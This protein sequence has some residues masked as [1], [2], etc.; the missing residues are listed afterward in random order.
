MEQICLEHPTEAAIERYL[1]NH[2][3]EAEFERVDTHLFVCGQCL[4]RVDEIR[5]FRVAL[6]DG[7]TLFRYESAERAEAKVGRA[8]VRPFAVSG[9]TGIA[10]MGIPRWLFGPAL[11]PA[12]AVMFGAL[13][14]ANL[15]QLGNREPGSPQPRSSEPRSNGHGGAPFDASLTA[16]RGDE[17]G[18]VVPVGRQVEFHLDVEGLGPATLSLEVVD[19]DGRPVEPAQSSVSAEHPTVQ[20]PAFASGTYFLRL[21]ATKDGHADQDHLLREF[22][23]QAK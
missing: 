14:V 2:A 18:P 17:A 6:R 7:F 16:L 12:A 9:L 11:W 8:V 22:S 13:L 3:P 1:F 10:R 15:Q 5:E 20:L 4:D 19:G 21:Y 23:F